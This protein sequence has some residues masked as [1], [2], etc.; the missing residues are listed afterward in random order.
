MCRLEEYGLRGR[1]AG[2]LSVSWISCLL[3]VILLSV[4]LLSVLF[5]VSKETDLLRKEGRRPEE[6]CFRDWMC[7]LGLKTDKVY[8]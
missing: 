5:R 3:S 2:S 1:N 6:M 7:T 8:L 4:G